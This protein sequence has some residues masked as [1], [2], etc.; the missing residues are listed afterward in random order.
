VNKQALCCIVF[1]LASRLFATI[2]Q[3]Q[4]AAKWNQTNT[5][6]CQIPLNRTG[7]GN[8]LLVWTS[9][10]NT[11]TAFTASVA[12]LPSNN[13]YASAVGPALQSD[14]NPPVSA[15]I[16]FAG[17][18]AGGSDTVTVTY[19]GQVTSASCVIAEYSGLDTVA[20]F[21][22][23]AQAVSNSVG[24]NMDSGTAVTANA[25]LLL[26]AAATTDNG[27]PQIAYPPWTSIQSSGGSTTFYQVV[28][29]NTTLERATATNNT[30][31]GGHWIMQMVVFRA[32]GWGLG[33]FAGGSPLFADGLSISNPGVWAAGVETDYHSVNLNAFSP[34]TSGGQQAPMSQISTTAIEGGEVVPSSATVHAAIGVAGYTVNNSTTTQSAGGYF[35]GLCTG[36]N[37]PNCQG[38][39]ALT[40][41]LPGETGN[42]LVGEE[43]DVDTLGKPK[44]LFGLIITGG[45]KGDLS[46]AGAVGVDISRGSD[47]TQQW[48]NGFSVGQNAVSGAAFQATPACAS[49]SGA[50]RSE[51]YQA[52]YQDSGNHWH[53]GGSWYIDSAGNLVLQPATSNLNVRV[54]GN[55][56][57]AGNVE[58]MGG[59]KHFKIDDPLDPANKY[60]YHAS[61]ESPDM[62]NIYNGNITTNSRGIALVTLP[63]YFEALNRD[64]RYQLTV[65]GQFAQAIVAQEIRHNHFTIQTSKPNVRVSWQVTGIRHDAYAEAHPSPV[66]VDKPVAE[67]GHYLHPEL[68]GASE[69]QGT[70]HL[71]N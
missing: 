47:S 54:N 69:V 32:A 44:A 26:F 51:I 41:D 53:C 20:P 25:N 22:S 19:S 58:A 13:M 10:Q 59:T 24:S 36:S 11:T 61:V 8:L 12:D 56:N 37:I 38:V 68:F 23:G 16:F 64:F 42:R 18:I 45:L 15:Q 4:S 27:T 31:P 50:C 33:N 34:T 40:G 17:N 2:S 5:T 65:I 55:L 66:E 49:G 3:Q 48:Q 1:I 39:N 30:V 6:T 71:T 29:G 7:K 46:T 21:D 70:L 14:S 67:R 43:I 63:D 52:C 57:V 35:Y 62:M 28:S 60:L 9:W